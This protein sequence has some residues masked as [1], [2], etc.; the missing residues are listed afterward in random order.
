MS[1]QH[2]SLHQSRN[3]YSVRVGGGRAGTSDSVLVLEDQ[4]EIF[5]HGFGRMQVA[6]ELSVEEMTLLGNILT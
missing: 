5:H 3:R 2:A 6:E 1:Y 4:I